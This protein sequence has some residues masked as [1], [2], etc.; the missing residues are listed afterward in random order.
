MQ[1]KPGKDGESRFAYVDTNS[2]C[3]SK[4]YG[5]HLSLERMVSLYKTKHLQIYACFYGTTFKS[6]YRLITDIETLGPVHL[7]K[8]IEPP[9]DNG[10]WV[11]GPAADNGRGD[12]CVLL[13]PC[14]DCLHLPIV[15]CARHNA[16]S[17]E[18]K[19]SC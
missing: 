17:Q 1:V 16:Y 9:Q 15:V 3:K 19:D 6:R 11:V 8:L 12:L 14:N 4:N 5:V 7:R 18:A 2:H 10:T 13:A